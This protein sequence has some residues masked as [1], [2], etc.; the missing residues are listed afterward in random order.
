MAL[1]LNDRVKETSTTTGLSDFALGGAAT[2]FQSFSAGVG[3]N[4][5][6]YYAVYDATDWEVGLGTLSGDGLTLARTTIYK[7]SNANNKVNFGA[8]AKSVFVTY[9][10]DIAS[11]ALQPSD[12]V[13]S[14]TNDAGY[15]GS[16]DIGVNVQAYDANI[17]TATNTQTLTNK[18][19]TGL[20]ETKVA[21]GA[22]NIDLSTGN[23]FT[24]TI[25]GATTLTVSNTATSGSVSAFVLELTN[26]GSAT[27]TFFSGVTWAA[28]T[29][30]TLTA[31]GVDVLG[32][33]TTDGGTTWRGFV[34]GLGMA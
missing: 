28:A 33:F 25:A 23:Y 9:P 27:V 1:I 14:L 34:L 20:K 2:G 30:P 31:S 10:A 13:S 5:T 19:V 18:T 8:G 11:S 4:N 24:K 6:T 7:S 17:T 32:F 15:I 21:M 26:G 29:A 12:N 16:A 22:D 3:A